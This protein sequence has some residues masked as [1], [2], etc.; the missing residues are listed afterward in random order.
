MILIL[1]FG[2]VLQEEKKGG[3]EKVEEKKEAEEKKIE[4]VKKDEVK[5]DK[6]VEKEK[7]AAPAPGPPP[8]IVMRVFMH[9]EGCAK[10]V[11]A[12]L[13]GFP[14]LASFLL[15]CVCNFVVFDAGLFWIKRIE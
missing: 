2:V 9:C 13:K 15:I 11:R 3:E 1:N 5:E 14:G 8:V 7:E 12:C 6:K 10:K 4:E